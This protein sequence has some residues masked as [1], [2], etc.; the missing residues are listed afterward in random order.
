[1]KYFWELLISA[2]KDSKQASSFGMQVKGCTNRGDNIIICCVENLATVNREVLY[3]R[4]Q[5]LIS[6]LFLTNKN[7]KYIAY[8][9]TQNNRH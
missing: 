8:L 3:C 4:L 6:E 1:M 9:A 5:I 7:T 2:V